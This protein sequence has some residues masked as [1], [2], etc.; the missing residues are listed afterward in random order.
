MVE[1]FHPSLPSASARPAAGR[2]AHRSARAPAR[3]AR[4]EVGPRVGKGRQEAPRL[5]E[6]GLQFHAEI[7]GLACSLP[8][9]QAKLLFQEEGVYD[10]P[11]GGVEDNSCP[12]DV[13]VSKRLSL[14][15]G[16]IGDCVFL[17]FEC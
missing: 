7:H 12:L 17:E 5:Q 11:D 10:Q 2:R 4:G 14:N 1:R 15:F 8:G 3:S 9:L 16:L 6:Q 13:Q